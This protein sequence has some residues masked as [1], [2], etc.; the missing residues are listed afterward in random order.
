M[1]TS[2]SKNK[3]SLSY[4]PVWCLQDVL[5]SRGDGGSQVLG[6]RTQAEALREQLEESQAAQVALAVQD[7]E[8]Q[9]VSVLQGASQAEHRALSDDFDSQSQNTQLWVKD[10]QLELQS[11]GSHTPPED[12]K[13]AAQVCLAS[14]LL[15]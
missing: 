9:W 1:I 11:V 3:A 10:R 2:F 5:A 13:Q 7:A 12:R 4:C 15:R 6:L 14:V 8:Q